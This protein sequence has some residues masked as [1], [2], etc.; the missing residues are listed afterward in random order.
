MNSG[1][2]ESSRNSAGVVCAKKVIALFF[3]GCGNKIGANREMQF[4]GGGGREAD[5][6][7]LLNSGI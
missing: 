4:G 3:F 1:N 2:T 5:D 6:A 7:V